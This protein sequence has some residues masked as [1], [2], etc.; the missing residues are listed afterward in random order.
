[1]RRNLEPSHKGDDFAENR[2]IACIDRFHRV[3]F[4]LKAN[5]TALFI[6]RL[7]RCFIVD[8]GDHDLSVHSVRLLA[9]NDE[10]TVEDTGVDH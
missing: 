9:H 10:I 6:K 2:G 5:A 8:H 3:V 4:R 1:M 7:H